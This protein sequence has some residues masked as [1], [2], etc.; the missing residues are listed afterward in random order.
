M[1]SNIK[2]TM[3]PPTAAKQD[4]PPQN[5]AKQDEHPKKGRKLSGHP[6]GSLLSRQLWFNSNSNTETA[7]LKT[8]AG[9]SSKVQKNT[10][11]YVCKT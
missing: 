9:W 7:K 3:S 4:E 6:Q 10:Q 2:Q 1:N 11:E 5:A 8:A